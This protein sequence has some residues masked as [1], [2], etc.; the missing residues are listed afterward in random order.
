MWCGTE[1]TNTWMWYVC[2]KC[3]FRICMSCYMSHSGRYAANGG[4]KCSQ[5]MLGWLKGPMKLA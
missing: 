3:G 5:C 4:G 2:D 1:Y